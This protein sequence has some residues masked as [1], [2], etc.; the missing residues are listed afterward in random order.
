MKIEVHGDIKSL[1]I[2]GVEMIK[3]KTKNLAQE[4]KKHLGVKEYTGIVET[5]QKWYYGSLVKDAWCAT[6]MSY[7]AEQC[8]LSEQIGKH[9]NVDKM[10]EYMEKRGKIKMSPSYGGS[11]KPKK[12]DVVFFSKGNTYTDCTHVGTVLSISGDNIT[13][14]GGNTGDAITTRINNMRY[15]KY[16]VCFGEVDY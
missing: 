1:V 7:F 4:F 2:D 15:D 13:W 16:L 14:V 6:S 8:N 11:Y 9:E 3:P 5:I 12:G 10:K